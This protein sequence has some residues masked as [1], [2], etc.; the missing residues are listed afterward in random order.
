M[1]SSRSFATSSGCLRS[2]E[3]EHVDLIVFQFCRKKWFKFKIVIWRTLFSGKFCNEN[4]QWQDRPLS[5]KDS[6]R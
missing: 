1:S 5:A 6:G 4:T 3:M 2:A